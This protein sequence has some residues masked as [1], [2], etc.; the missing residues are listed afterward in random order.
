NE[1]VL[2]LEEGII[3]SPRDGDIGAIMGLGFPPFFGGPFRYVDSIGAGVALDKLEN[4]ASRLAPRF[5]PSGL[6]RNLTIHNKK[7]YS[8]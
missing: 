2:C 7:F 8:D 1:A 4:L 5:V 6:L 3:R